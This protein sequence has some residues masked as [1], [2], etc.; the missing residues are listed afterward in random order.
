[1]DVPYKM[2]VIQSLISQQCASDEM[3]N[4]SQ[5]DEGS[6]IVIDKF[7]LMVCLIRKSG[8]QSWLRYLRAA[9]GLDKLHVKLQDS[10]VEFQVNR[11]LTY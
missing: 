6:V 1:M 5:L 11:M 8:T 2:R 4:R 7:K 9:Q 10:Y 3:R